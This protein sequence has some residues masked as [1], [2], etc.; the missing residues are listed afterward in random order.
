MNLMRIDK[1]YLNEK[2]MKA[3]FASTAKPILVC[4]YR[5][6]YE[7]H[8]DIQ[9]E[10]RIQILVDAVRWGASGIDLEADAFDPSPG[11]LEWTEESRRYSLN[12]R[13]RP[14]DWTMKAGAVRKQKELIRKIHKLNGEVLLSA[15]TRIHLSAERA[16]SMGQEMESRGPDFI[17]LVS[18]DCSY[19]DLLDT[20]KATIDLKKGVKVPYIMMSHGDHSKIGRVVC[21]MLGS[22]LAFCTQPHSPGGFPLQPPIRSMKEAFENVDWTVTRPPEEQRWL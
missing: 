20:M 13:S 2:D 16:V 1:K 14:R 18:V 10:E 3:V 6:N 5:W 19:E 4:Y 17:K 9:E 15:H 8:L 22:M 11:P 12:R 21:P 7:R